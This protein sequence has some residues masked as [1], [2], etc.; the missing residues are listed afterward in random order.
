MSDYDRPPGPLAKL[1]IAFCL[2]VIA[3][4]TSASIIGMTGAL[5]RMHNA[6]PDDECGLAREFCDERRRV[7]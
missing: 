4:M 7:H 5:D 6:Y 1:L 2:A 3:V